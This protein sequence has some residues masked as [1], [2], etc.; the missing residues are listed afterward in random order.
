MCDLMSVKTF[1]VKQMKILYVLSGLEAVT[2]E[3]S[4]CMV[5]MG[6]MVIVLPN[7]ADFSGTSSVKTVADNN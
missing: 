2:P 6:F 1:N 5:I 4:C 7:A 3:S